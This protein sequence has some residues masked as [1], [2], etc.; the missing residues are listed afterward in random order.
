MATPDGLGQ[1]GFGG[2]EQGGGGTSGDWE[3]GKNTSIDGGCHQ[4]LL[5]NLGFPGGEIVLP[6]AFPGL[7]QAATYQVGVSCGG[8]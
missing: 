7:H 5:G 4:S 3:R 2:A 8:V 6:D 1:P